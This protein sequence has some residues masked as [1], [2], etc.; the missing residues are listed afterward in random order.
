[1]SIFESLESTNKLSPSPWKAPKD[2]A[3]PK[4]V[5]GGKSLRYPTR[6]PVL[7]FPNYRVSSWH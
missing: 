2:L 1:M 7:T 3:E 4:S 5:E 6:P